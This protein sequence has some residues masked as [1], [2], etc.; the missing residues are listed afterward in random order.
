VSTVFNEG[1]SIFTVHNN[2]FDKIQILVDS[3]FSELG[4]DTSRGQGHCWY[5]IWGEKNKFGR[6]VRYSFKVTFES[7]GD[8]I[9]IQIKSEELGA[10]RDEIGK[11]NEYLSAAMNH[12]CT[13]FKDADL[14]ATVKTGSYWVPALGDLP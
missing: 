2:D 10:S 8:N 5:Y 4:Y 3:A 14:S 11:I 6:P 7:V 1:N 13:K 9:I 12:I